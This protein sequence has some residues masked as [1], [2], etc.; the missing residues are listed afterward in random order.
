VSR[1]GPSVVLV[2]AAILLLAP[3]LVLGAISGHD[4]PYHLKWA[5]EFQEQ[6]RA[7]ILYPRWLPDSFNGIGAPV[8]YF[9]P[10]LA[11][12][13]DAL[14]NVATGNLL[15]VTYNLSV[16]RLVI[17]A[18]SGLT[19][20]LWLERSG[21]SPRLALWGAIAYMAAP[22]HLFAHY[23]RAALTE[24]SAY[25]L[26]PLVMLA[27]R[28][29]ARG[30]MGGPMG[31]A[32]LAAAYGALAL[33]HLP[34]LLLVSYTALP[35][36]VLYVAWQLGDRR[37][38][39]A[40]LVRSALGGVLGTGLA[41]IY[42]VPVLTLQKWI[43]A[44]VLLELNVRDFVLIADGER[45][46]S[47]LRALAWATLSYAIAAAA[48]L[49]IAGQGGIERRWRS[50]A[51]FW[52]ILGLAC[53]L[54][55]S[56]LVPWF[57]DLPK[58]ANIQFPIR[59]LAVVE[60]AI[61]TAL[62]R[63][64]WPVRSRTGLVMLAAAVVAFIPAIYSLGT[65]IANYVAQPRPEVDRPR[66]DAFEYLPAGFVRSDDDGFPLQSVTVPTISCTPMPAVCRAVEGRF[67]DL[68]IEVDGDAPSTVVVRRFYFPAWQL[69]PALPVGA[70]DGQRLVSFTAPSGRH[71]WQLTRRTLPE[72][73][74]GQAI[75]GLS[76]ILL[77]G[78]ATIGR[79]R[80]FLSRS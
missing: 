3:S 73:R 69:E 13:I 40:F 9:Y 53:T 14:V 37:Q 1:L 56:G 63:T 28:Q 15:P 75:T 43:Q 24:F 51:A 20:H 19:M 74:W 31:I 29:T 36:Y 45:A 79:R 77:L 70:T 50:E 27:V 21:S 78:V 23:V 41:A 57:W 12:W 49:V 6:F 72:E 22:N 7:G 30:P 62:C 47:W 33:T 10:P 32:C 55:V 17:L 25:A 64:P 66:F 61:I 8:F 60:F 59:L 44:D 67:G 16:S 38:A 80:R 46:G 35:M 48:V 4:Q 76:F 39:F 71:I 5:S 2:A 18:A 11:Y 34:M 65:D 58:L 68:R 42:L 26:L 54:F 52:A